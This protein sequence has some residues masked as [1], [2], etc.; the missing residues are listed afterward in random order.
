MA[1][2]VVAQ[3]P[4]I[5]GSVRRV[6]HLLND[7]GRAAVETAE[8][9]ADGV[10]T[11]AELAA[12]LTTPHRAFVP[13]VPYEVG[14]VAQYREYRSTADAHS[15]VKALLA[16]PHDNCHVCGAEMTAA[17]SRG[18]MILDCPGCESVSRWVLNPASKFACEA[19]ATGHRDYTALFR[20]E[21]AEQTELLRDIVGNPYRP[22]AF[23]PAW[24]T[25]TVVTL[26]RQMYDSREFVAMPIL[27]DALQDAGGEDKQVLTHCRE[28]RVH[29]RGCWVCDAVLGKAQR[30]RPAARASR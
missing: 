21:S 15:A 7:A 4:P 27:A 11:E 18:T 3:A 25:D 22:V 14:D 2:G 13:D 6:A 19:R 8:R 23:D 16:L 28:P 30:Q 17:L 20:A 12:L 1:P 24:R 10:A 5:R 9:F 29:V 26:A